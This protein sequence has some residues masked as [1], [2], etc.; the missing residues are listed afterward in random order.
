L[1]SLLAAH[2]RPVDQ[3]APPLKGRPKSGLTPPDSREVVPESHTIREMSD[4]STL[5]LRQ[6]SRTNVIALASLAIASQLR[7]GRGPEL[8]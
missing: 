6:W 5:F 3:F 2:R 7:F 4:Q 1:L 8:A